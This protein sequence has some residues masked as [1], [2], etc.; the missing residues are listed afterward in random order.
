[1]DTT[2]NGAEILLAVDA[3]AEGAGIGAFI[4]DRLD[5]ET[6]EMGLND[7]FNEVQ[8]THPKREA[9][10]RRLEARGFEGI[11]AWRSAQPD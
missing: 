7:M 10:T 11:P 3:G 9:V 4:R 8:A 1:M 2:W 6:A 5:A